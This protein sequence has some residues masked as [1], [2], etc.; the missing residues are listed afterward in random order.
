MS[1]SVDIAPLDEALTFACTRS[2][3]GERLIAVRFYQEDQIRGVDLSSLRS[4]AS[5]DAID[6]I[7]RL[8]Q[9]AIRAFI[10]A[11]KDEVEVSSNRLGLPIRLDDQNI[12]VGTNYA[13]H[14]AESTVVGSPFLFPKIVQPTAW[15]APIP[16]GD[17]LLDYEVEL[18]LVPLEPLIPGRPVSGGLILGNDVTDR[19]V[20]MRNVDIADPQS[21]KGFTSGK[22]GPNYMPV[23]DLFVVPRNL[24]SFISGLTLQLSVNGQVRQHAAATDWIWDLEEIVRQCRLKRDVRWAYWGGEARLAVCEDGAIPARTVIMAGTPAGTVFQGVPTKDRLIGALAWL[25]SGRKKPLI[26]H[27]I[28]RHIK[29]ARAA[30]AYLQPGDRVDIRVDRLGCLSN[31]IAASL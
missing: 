23:G 27:V 11:A 13:E 19:A 4:S 28:E 8:G 25:L 9:D 22:S 20:L 5:E 24:T 29:S 14:A 6:L 2:E 1:R 16:A 17:A 31:R 30:K 21:G 18:C 15:D 10:Q 7:G 3:E 12:G 26:A